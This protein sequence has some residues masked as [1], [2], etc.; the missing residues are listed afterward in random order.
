MCGIKNGCRCITLGGAGRGAI[1][2]GAPLVRSARGVLAR[3]T[4]ITITTICTI[5]IVTSLALRVLWIC[6][7]YS[8]GRATAV[9]RRAAA[10][11]ATVITTA[12]RAV[13]TVRLLGIVLIVVC[14][15]VRGAATVHVAAVVAI[16]RVIVRAGIGGGRGRRQRS[17]GGPRGHRRAATVRL[18]LVVV[19]VH[20]ED[21]LHVVGETGAADS[22]MKIVFG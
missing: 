10:A 21:H 22:S 8:G 13:R 20:L 15:R 11:I 12:A 17:G 19:R 3:T 16:V 18:R 6:S 7:S 1:G 4:I 9:A 2:G 5:T 14:G